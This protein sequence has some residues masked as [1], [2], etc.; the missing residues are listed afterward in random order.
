MH[1]LNWIGNSGVIFPYCDEVASSRRSIKVTENDSE[2]T[3][4]KCL[5]IM[6][7]NQLH[8]TANSGDNNSDL[9]VG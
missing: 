8:P 1:K 6:A 7:N 5:A 3:C 9:S 4:K 2:V